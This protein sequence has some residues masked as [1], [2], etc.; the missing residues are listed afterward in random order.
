MDHHSEHDDA[1]GKKHVHTRNVP[2]AK[3]AQFKED[4]QHEAKI[5]QAQLKDEAKHT[6]AKLQEALTQQEAR[7]RIIQIAIIV[8]VIIAI[9]GIVRSCAAPSASDTSQASTESQETANAANDSSS[10]DASS[11]EASQDETSNDETS[12]DESANTASS[13]TPDRSLSSNRTLAFDKKGLGMFSGSVNLNVPCYMQYP[14]LPTGCESVALTNTLRY[15]DFDLSKTEIAANWIPQSDYDFVYSFWGD[16][17][18]YSGGFI[19]P[20]GL[21]NAAN[22]FLTSN[23]SDLRAHDISGTPF[24]QLLWYVSQG[25]PVIVWTT[26]NMSPVGSPVIEADGYTGYSNEHAVVLEG[27]DS[28]TGIV[29]ISDSISGMVPRNETVFA[30]IYQDLGSNAVVITRES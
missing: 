24:P 4:A 12:S 27:Y 1:A 6:S 30:Q 21:T 20:P 28:T 19:M 2:P 16:P 22:D 29:L 23:G 17:F 13:A 11:D 10:E 18:T 14:E 8:V 3:H 7:N 25:E 15:W 5:S 9:V 26:V